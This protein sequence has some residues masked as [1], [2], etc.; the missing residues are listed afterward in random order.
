MTLRANTTK[1][2][3]AAFTLAEVLAALLFM[4][5]VIPV[6]IGALRV[7]SKAGEVARRKT[8]ATRIAEAV[9]NENIALTNVNASGQS[10]TIIE[11]NREFQWRL[12][13]EAWNQGVTNV[14]PQVSSSAGVNASVQPQFNQ[15]NASQISMNLLS[16]EVFYRV[17]DGEYSVK[18]STLASLQ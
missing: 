2:G 5:I 1:R 8:E 11:G 10:G 14:L 18:L 9:L 7:A 3:S 16:V 17:Q 4:A 15:V 12:R 6:A 13:S